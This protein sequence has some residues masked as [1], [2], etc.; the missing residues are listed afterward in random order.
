MAKDMNRERQGPALNSLLAASHPVCLQDKVSD[1]MFQGQREENG[2]KCPEWNGRANLRHN[3]IL[4]I[5]VTPLMPPCHCVLVICACS[6][7]KGRG[8]GGY[9]MVL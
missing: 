6:G 1:K 5:E 2:A 3:N 4:S 9:G 8:H 7:S